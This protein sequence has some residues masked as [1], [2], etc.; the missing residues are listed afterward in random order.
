MRRTSTTEPKAVQL[1]HAENC[2]IVAEH[3]IAG[4]GRRVDVGVALSLRWSAGMSRNPSPHQIRQLAALAFR[5]RMR[6]YTDPDAAPLLRKPEHG[7]TPL[8]AEE[9]EH[10]V[11]EGLIT[12]ARSTV[13]AVAGS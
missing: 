13:V 8:S 1:M 2:F 7:E 3:G 11:F 4:G 6:G 5:N 12:T 9:I 10:G